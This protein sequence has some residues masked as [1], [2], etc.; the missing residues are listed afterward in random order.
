MAYGSTDA[1]SEDESL[2]NGQRAEEN[3]NGPKTAWTQVKAF[4][5]ENI[6][7]FFVFLAQMFASIVSLHLL[8]LIL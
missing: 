2:L 1:P 4:Y 7:L 5:S 6:G 8:F 3:G